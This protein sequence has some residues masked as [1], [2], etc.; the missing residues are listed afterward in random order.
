MY[1]CFDLLGD[2]NEPSN[3]DKFQTVAIT[4]PKK[5][6]TKERKIQKC[7]PH[8]QALDS[9]S[10]LRPHCVGK[11]IAVN[12]TNEWK[13]QINGHLYDGYEGQTNLKDEG[14]LSENNFDHK[15]GSIETMPSV[16]TF[17]YST[18]IYVMTIFVSLNFSSTTF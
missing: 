17:G 16:F 13:L 18:I 6:F 14:T 11:N 3:P 7:C 12:V 8:G 5:R 9:T 10:W 15:V 4:C 2:S 1:F